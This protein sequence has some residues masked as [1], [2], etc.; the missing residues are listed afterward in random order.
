MER[1]I[2][3]IIFFYVD[4]FLSLSYDDTN[5]KAEDHETMSNRLRKI[6]MA[7]IRNDLITL[8]VNEAGQIEH[9][10]MKGAPNIIARPIGFVPRHPENK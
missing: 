2:F 8:R 9:L 7:T 6:S 1:I 4:M 3:I 5:E 10:S